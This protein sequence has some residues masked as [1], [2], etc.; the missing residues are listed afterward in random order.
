MTLGNYTSE[1]TYVF[2]I[3]ALSFATLT[4]FILRFW[5]QV[6][7]DVVELER[8]ER[9]TQFGVFAACLSTIFVTIS[10]MA[11]V[12]L[13]IVGITLIL[14]GRNRRSSECISKK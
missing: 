3:G 2:F 6:Y 10:I 7:G 1:L 9:L 5:K 12:T 14:I 13:L 11:S 8:G 4:L